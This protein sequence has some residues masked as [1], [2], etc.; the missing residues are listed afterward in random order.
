QAVFSPTG[1]APHVIVAGQAHLL[2]A[3]GG[4]HRMERMKALLNVLEEKERLVQLL[5]PAPSAHGLQVRL[6]SDTP[7]AA[8]APPSSPGPAPPF[9]GAG[10]LSVV[11]PPYGPGDRPVGTIAVIGPTRMNYSKVI[12]LVDFTAE[13]VSGVLGAKR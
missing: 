9:A 11:A 5:H 4:E 12:P 3:E 2:H 8:L 1:G 7:L 13:L 6:G 10:A